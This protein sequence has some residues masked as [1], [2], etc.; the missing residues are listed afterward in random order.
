ML[1]VARLYIFSEFKTFAF[2]SQSHSICSISSRK[3]KNSFFVTRQCN[4]TPWWRELTSGSWCHRTT[5]EVPSF[6]SY[7]HYLVDML[8]NRCLS[9]DNPFGFLRQSCCKPKQM[10]LWPL[11]TYTWET[12]FP[13]ISVV[14]TQCPDHSPSHLNLLATSGCSQTRTKYQMVWLWPISK[15]PLSQHISRVNTW[16][17]NDHKI[18]F[19]NVIRMS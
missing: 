7:P 14:S 3:I 9:L 11:V 15:I 10:F 19:R 13:R 6:T 17:Q 12:S 18:Q 8:C 16:W 2:S 5:S 4:I 1:S